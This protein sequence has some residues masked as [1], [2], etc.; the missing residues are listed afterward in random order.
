M[1][2]ILLEALIGTW[3]LL[4]PVHLTQKIGVVLLLCLPTLRLLLHISVVHLTF[5]KY[6]RLRDTLAGK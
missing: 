2:L 6:V 5:A 3:L 1:T 4:E